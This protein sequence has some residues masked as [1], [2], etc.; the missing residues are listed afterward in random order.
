MPPWMYHKSCKF[1]S[2]HR[3]EKMFG[4]NFLGDIVRRVLLE[5][6]EAKVVFNGI[7]SEK[8]RTKDSIISQ[9]ISLIE[10]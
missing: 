2:L 8:L 5:L 6:A 9:D 7:V 3:F 1:S 4:G 10:G